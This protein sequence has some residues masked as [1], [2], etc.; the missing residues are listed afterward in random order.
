M[1]PEFTIPGYAFLPAQSYYGEYDYSCDGTLVD[2][3]CAMHGTPADVYQAC[4]ADA[5]CALIVYYPETSYLGG[6]VSY[7]KGNTFVNLSAA[8]LNNRAVSYLKLGNNNVWLL[9]SSASASSG[10]DSGLSSG[11][12]AGIAIGCAVAGAV[13]AGGTMLVLAKKRRRMN[14]SPTTTKN[15]DASL[16][17]QGQLY[18]DR[19]KVSSTSASSRDV[20]LRNPQQQ[21]KH[22]S[23]F[24]VEDTDSPL[25][26]HP[27]H[28]DLP[29]GDND[30]I[31]TTTAAAAEESE[32]LPS[33]VLHPSPENAAIIEA[34]KASDYARY[35][36]AYSQIKWTLGGDGS[37]IELGRGAFSIVYKAKLEGST[38]LYAAK[39]IPLPDPRSQRSF[40]REAVTLF[41]LRHPNIVNFGAVCV[42]ERT[43]ILLQEFMENGSLFDQLK[44][45]E[46][47]AN[48]GR[49]TGW[50]KSGRKIVLGVI[51]ALHHLHSLH[52][53]HLDLKSANVLLTKDFTSK[54]SD[55]GFTRMWQSLESFGEASASSMQDS[56]VGT[57]AYV[58][59]FVFCFAVDW[60]VFITTPFVLI[61]TYHPPTLQMAPELL[62][63]GSVT[64]AADMYR[65]V[66]VCFI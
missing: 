50:F 22:A 34:F 15:S 36:C 2:G 32:D 14:T 27:V 46:A 39:V 38:L 24:A 35:Q 56:R 19:D 17:Q 16:R 37:R 45:T 11:A 62:L 41:H 55:V 20:Y 58:R 61:S 6:N 31:T 8:T 48:P 57:F 12:V 26:T 52:M 40:L 13:V 7:F 1:A 60:L 64:P 47:S 5:R 49:V 33:A 53:I 23:P 18:S 25:A 63:G 30:H 59:L 65:Y 43:G 10:S 66:Y 21:P 28:D 3:A 54:L 4:N 42:H 29:G 44:R 9:E 51:Q